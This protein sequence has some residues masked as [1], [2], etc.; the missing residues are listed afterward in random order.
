MLTEE[1]RYVLRSLKEVHR[2]RFT[3]NRSGMNCFPEL[4]KMI[5][6]GIKADWVN[7]GLI[8][9]LYMNLSNI[10][11]KETDNLF[12]DA[13]LIAGSLNEEHFVAKFS[14]CLQRMEIID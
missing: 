2:V 11:I 10:E 1:V 7:E 13:Y 4:Y 3:F 6:N 8:K 14:S 12:V 9:T 5:G